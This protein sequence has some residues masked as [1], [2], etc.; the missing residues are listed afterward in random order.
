MS[1]PWYYLERPTRMVLLRC[2]YAICTFTY[3]VFVGLNW[4][5]YVPSRAEVLA[6]RS[7]REEILH[8]RRTDQK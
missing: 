4:K 2:Y 6:G 5:S 8:P 7:L 1:M 3:P